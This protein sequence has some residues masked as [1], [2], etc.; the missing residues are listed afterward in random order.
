MVTEFRGLVFDCV[1]SAI[2][3]RG[4]AYQDDSLQ[5]CAYPGAQPGQAFINGADYYEA[6]YAFESSHVWRNVG[7]IIAMTLAYVALSLFLLEVSEWSS[8]SASGIKF[9][10]KQQS[11]VSKADEESN[12]GSA[13]SQLHDD[14]DSQQAE[15][16]GVKAT[17]SVF[18]WKNLSYDVSVAGSERRLLDEVSG[19]CKPGEMT[20]L[21]GASGAGK[22]TRKFTGRSKQCTSQLTISQS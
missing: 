12:T 14:T 2:V 5:T 8:A 1:D 17:T 18:T 10:K 22:S 3:P 7:I 13:A 11:L 15:A 9:S 6:Y 16:V 4:S 20:A 19:Y 21:V